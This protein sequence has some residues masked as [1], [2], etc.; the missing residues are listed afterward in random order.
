MRVSTFSI[1]FLSFL[2][3]WQDRLKQKCDQYPTP[4]D[5]DCVICYEGCDGVKDYRRFRAPCCGRF[6]HRDC[7]QRYASTSGQGHFKCANCNNRGAILKELHRMG[8]YIPVKDADWESSEHS[9][10]YDYEGKRI[11]ENWTPLCVQ[12]APLVLWLPFS[13]PLFVTPL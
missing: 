3:I 11:V 7:M 12:Q 6:F 13:S 9:E 1:I 2:N 10:F 8:F 4:P 5:R